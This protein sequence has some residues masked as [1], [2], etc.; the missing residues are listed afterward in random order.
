MR[1]LNLTAILI[2]L[3]ASSVPGEA[4]RLPDAD[5]A[6]WGVNLGHGGHGMDLGASI[7]SPRFGDLAVR[8]ALNHARWAEFENGPAPD[9][10][11]VGRV[12]A[13]RARSSAPL[14]SWTS[15]P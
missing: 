14:W 11:R 4:Q 8:A 7:D 5:G 2:V 10:P 1:V 6:R 13:L 3:L 12:S 15:G 9:D